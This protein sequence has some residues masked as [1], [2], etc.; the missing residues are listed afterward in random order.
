M[1]YTEK[2]QAKVLVRVAEMGSS[3]AREQIRRRN[4]PKLRDRSKQGS[5]ETQGRGDSDFAGLEV[6]KN[7][8]GA[9]DCRLAFVEL[10]VLLVVEIVGTVVITAVAEQVVVDEGFAE[11]VAVLVAVFVAASIEVV[12]LPVV[13]AELRAGVAA[14]VAARTSFVVVASEVGKF[15]DLVLKYASKSEAEG[16]DRGCVSFVIALVVAP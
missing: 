16:G 7:A 8:E 13:V 5:G 10:E 15:A 12:V 11:V 4:V 14:A 2:A 9:R 3:S 1:S 6:A